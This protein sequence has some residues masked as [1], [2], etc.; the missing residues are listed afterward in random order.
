MTQRRG[1]ATTLAAGA[2]LLSSCSGDSPSDPSATA[3]ASPTESGTVV[4]DVAAPTAPDDDDLDL[5][6]S[7]PREDSYYPDVGDPGIDALHYGLSLRWDPAALLLSARER[8]TFR[9]AET[10]E[11]FQLDFGEDLEITELSVDGE[12]AEW[13]QEGKDLVVDHAVEEDR[14]YV[15]ELTYSGLPDPVEVP[16][17]RT[18]FTRTG[19]TVS[20]GG[21]TWT[22]QEP[23]GAYTWYA[24]N[25]HPSDKA[26]YDFT[27]AVPSPWSGVANG[28]LLEESDDGDLRTTTWHLA[29]P[30]ASY[31]VTTAFDDYEM[32]RDESASGVPITY[33]TPRSD[34]KTLQRLKVTPEAMAWL[35]DL[36]GPYPFDTFGTVVVDSESGMETQTMV[37]LGDT[38]YTLSSPVI[39]HELAH[40]W[41]GDQVTPNDW[42]DVWMNEGMVMYLQGMWEAEQKGIPVA[43]QMDEWAQFEESL[44]KEA[45]PPAAYFPDY[46]GSSNI[47]YG[48]ALMFHELREIVGDERFFTMVRGWPAANDNANADREGFL[49]YM[50]ES[51]GEELSAFFDA[52]LLGETTPPR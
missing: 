50:E 29:E 15:L 42:R 43:A 1:L 34:P 10:D 33:W 12:A 48:P 38:R 30:A 52:W 47:Y 28:E 24:V 32:T 7:E 46:F 3:P 25:D 31:L 40:Q 9:A 51:T 49:A 26:L 2:L 18:D 22:M 27:L 44:R 5:G 11:E 23:F 41:Y 16:V 35:E 45:G 17:H 4:D 36:L 13:V 37:T 21:G 19:W 39:V 8:L 14:R 20:D 6:V